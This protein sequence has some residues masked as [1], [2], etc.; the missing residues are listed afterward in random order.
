ERHETVQGLTGIAKAPSGRKVSPVRRGMN[1]YPQEAVFGVVSQL[2]VPQ[3][4]AVD[5]AL[6]GLADELHPLLSC[7]A[8]RRT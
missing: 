1:A 3:L 5:V 2:L 7:V 8:V 4:D 6:H